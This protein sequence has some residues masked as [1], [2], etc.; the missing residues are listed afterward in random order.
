MSIAPDLAG[1]HV[2]LTT[3]FDPDSGAVDLDALADQATWLLDHGIRG[4]AP[5]GPLGEFESLDHDER[6]AV[7][8]TIASVTTGRATLIVGVSA[9]DH[10]GAGDHAEHAASVGA[11]AVLLLPPTNHAPTSTELID[12]YR[13]VAQHDVPVIVVNDP[14]STRIDLTPEIVA[15]L[16]RIEGI[17][18]VTESSGDVRRL[19]DIAERAPHLTL[20]CGSDDLAL[21]SAVMGASGWVGGFAGALPLESTRLFQLAQG[22][23][24]E[25]ALGIYRGMLPLLRWCSRS[26]AVE[27]VKCALDHLGRPGGG[28]P[29]PPRR[30]VDEIEREIIA[31]QVD[32]ARAA[33]A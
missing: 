17:V 9:P 1:V 28:P 33:A 25:R 3:P 26:R 21:E 30:V 32:R 19:T 10:R 18:A 12:H 11:D 13:S 4:L 7:V 2:A 14:S 24:V 31:R 6:R 5:N 8:E 15:E 22:G 29:R 27:A 16:G 23:D 20:L